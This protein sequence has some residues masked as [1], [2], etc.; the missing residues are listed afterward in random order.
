M[1][2]RIEKLEALLKATRQL[3]AAEKAVVK[4]SEKERQAFNDNAT[5]KRRA[6]LSDNTVSCCEDRDYKRSVVHALS[7]DAGVADLREPE[8]Y[9]TREIRQS[10]GLGHGIEKLWTP[11]QPEQLK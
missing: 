8:H 9:A 2:D 3:I 10:A 4:A 1:N 6:N 11:A 5:P 7:V